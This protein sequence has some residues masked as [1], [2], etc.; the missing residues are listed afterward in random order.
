MSTQGTR[1]HGLSTSNGPGS[2]A[3][4]PTPAARPVTRMATMVGS[5]AMAAWAQL[6]GTTGAEHAGN[7]PPRSAGKDPVRRALQQGLVRAK[8]TVSQPHDP[9]EQEADRRMPEPWT[10]ATSVGLKSACPSCA[11]A[12]TTC[13]TFADQTHLHRA[14]AA[15]TGPPVTSVRSPLAALRG[16]GQPIQK[17]ICDAFGLRSESRS[18]SKNLVRAIARQYR[19]EARVLMPS[20]LGPYAGHLREA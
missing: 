15:S 9:D 14:A 5:A 3:A 1:Q 4:R 7:D 11:A 6:P 16:R 12:G 19:R 20:K 8:L 17:R 2:P 18:R 13:P 10:A